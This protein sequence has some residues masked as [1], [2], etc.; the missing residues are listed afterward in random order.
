MND[1]TQF[2]D[3]LMSLQTDARATKCVLED[4]R[5]EHLF[6]NLFLPG[7]SPEIPDIRYL[8]EPLGLGSVKVTTLL[9]FRDGT[10]LNATK[11]IYLELG[12]SQAF[13]MIQQLLSNGF[14]EYDGPWEP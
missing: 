5:W 4:Y 10:N 1:L 2:T 6:K 11:R 7:A 14:V 9:L 13:D 3:K 12:E 8:F